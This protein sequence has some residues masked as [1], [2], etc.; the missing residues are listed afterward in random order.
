MEKKNQMTKININEAQFVSLFGGKPSVVDNFYQDKEYPDFTISNERMNKS[1]DVWYP[2][3][4]DRYNEDKSKIIHHIAFYTT[5]RML[6]NG[7]KIPYSGG[8][9]IYHS[10]KNI[11]FSRDQVEWVE[12]KIQKKY[13]NYS[14]EELYDQMI[15][16]SEKGFYESDMNSKN[17]VLKLLKD[18]FF[19]QY[20]NGSLK[21]VALWS[22]GRLNDTSDML[23]WL[24]SKN[25]FTKKLNYNTVMDYL[26]K[27]CDEIADSNN[28]FMGDDIFI[29][30]SWIENSLSKLN[31]V[32]TNKGT[33]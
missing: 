6:D 11:P 31:R 16:D 17:S 3:Y 12:K 9:K 24:Y 27:N 26:K 15:I 4:R 25:K 33:D 5:M 29:A 32:P 20:L 23:S 22:V 21:D 28:S 19:D 13:G 7:K 2:F 14:L 8:A 30:L 10:I 1:R 18:G